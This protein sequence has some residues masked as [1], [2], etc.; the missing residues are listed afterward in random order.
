MV[1]EVK[2]GAKNIRVP[3][4]RIG[5][6]IGDD[7]FRKKVLQAGFDGVGDFNEAFKAAGG[8]LGDAANKTKFLNSYLPKSEAPYRNII[9][10]RIKTKYEMLSG[11]ARPGTV[12]APENKVYWQAATAAEKEAIDKFP[13]DTKL[14]K[15]KRLTYVKKYLKN[16]GVPAKWLLNNLPRMGLYTAGAAAPIS[17][18][19]SAMLYAGTSKPAMGALPEESLKEQVLRGIDFGAPSANSQLLEQ[20]SQD[21]T[22]KAGGGMMNMN[23]MI[24]PI[25]M[26]NGGDPVQELKN[27]MLKAMTRKEG[28]RR[29][30]MNTGNPEMERKS[31]YGEMPQS[32]LI[33]LALQIAGQQGDTSEE[34]IRKIIMQLSQT[35][36]S[37]QQD[38]ANERRS[39]ISSGVASLID[40]LGMNRRTNLDRNVSASRTR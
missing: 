39:P 11:G 17:A 20:M 8:D 27:E 28:E 30:D 32:D 31:T 3:T 1:D 35:L 38:M 29:A 5:D 40:M 26:Q 37:L 23:E 4:K 33:K 12:G 16:A 2:K 25:G 24:R 6:T 22:M 15:Q 9:T 14:D 36:P 19:A 21:A 18:L 7:L 13:K 10:D 34:N